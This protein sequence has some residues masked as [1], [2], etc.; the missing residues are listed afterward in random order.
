M[1]EVILPGKFQLNIVGVSTAGHSDL[2]R[3]KIV[4]HVIRAFKQSF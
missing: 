4:K 1:K 2:E 3:S